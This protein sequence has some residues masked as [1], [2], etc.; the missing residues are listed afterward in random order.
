MIPLLLAASLAGAASCPPIVEPAQWGSRPD[1]IPASQKHTPRAVMLHHAGVV[2]DDR[3]DPADFVRKMQSW[4]KGR[5]GK[6]YWPDLPYHFL[7][8]RDG[9]VFRGRP[10]AYAPQSNTVYPL[11]G[12][13]GVELMGDFETQDPT[14][15]QVDSA[16]AL[17]ACLAREFKIALSGIRGHK[18]LVEGTDCPGSRF[19]ADFN[20]RVAAALSVP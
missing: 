10:L 7:I 2:V 8:A 12:N 9:R 18:D 14:A 5:A 6:D 15:A 4:G 19:P 13:I 11:K 3:R 1:P 17:V 20:G 16:V